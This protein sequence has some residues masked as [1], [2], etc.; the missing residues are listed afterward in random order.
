MR[1]LIQLQDKEIINELE[2]TLLKLKTKTNPLIKRSLKIAIP[3]KIAEQFILI[4]QIILFPYILFHLET[5]IFS[6]LIVLLIFCKEALLFFLKQ[7]KLKNHGNDHMTILTFFPGIYLFFL[8]LVLETD[9]SE[10]SLFLIIRGIYILIILSNVTSYMLELK[11]STIVLNCLALA[12]VISMINYFKFEDKVLS[13]EQ[14]INIAM[15]GT[16][17]FYVKLTLSNKYSIVQNFKITNEGQL[18]IDANQAKCKERELHNFLFSILDRITNLYI[19]MLR[20]SQC[21]YANS[22]FKFLCGNGNFETYLENF[23][24]IRTSID[25][26]YEDG[27]DQTDKVAKVLRCFYNYVS[28]TNLLEDLKKLYKDKRKDSNHERNFLLGIYEYNKR[29]FEIYFRFSCLPTG[30]ENLDLL[31][32]LAYELQEKNFESCI[33]QA[34]VVNSMMLNNK[35]GSSL[36]IPYHN[37]PTKRTLSLESIVIE[38]FSL[39]VNHNISKTMTY[40]LNLNN[41]SKDSFYNNDFSINLVNCH[42]KS[43]LSELNRSMKRRK[44]ANIKKNFSI[45]TKKVS[46]DGYS[47]SKSLKH[48]ALVKSNSDGFGLNVVNNSSMNPS[49]A[50]HELKT[51]LISIVSLCS[52]IKENCAD[53]HTLDHLEKISSIAQYSTILVIDFIDILQNKE[54]NIAIQTTPIKPILMFC[55]NILKSLALINSRNVECRFICFEDFENI[56]IDTDE[57]RLKQ[58]FLNFL[59]NSVKFTKSGSISIE[60]KI[61]LSHELVILIKDTGAGLNKT[62]LEKIKEQKFNS[63]H[64]DRKVNETGSGLGLNICFT[65]SKLLNYDISFDSELG[66][67]TEIQ[68]NLK[69]QYQWKRNSMS[70]IAEYQPSQLSLNSP[71]QESKQE[72]D[73]ND[74]FDFRM[75]S[76]MSFQ[77]TRRQSKSSDSPAICISRVKSIVSNRNLQVGSSPTGCGKTFVADEKPDVILVVDDN[78]LLRK[79]VKR[80]IDEIV[81]SN[82]LDYVVME[83]VDG[84]DIVKHVI[85]DQTKG[86]KIKFVFTDENMEYYNG[87]IASKMLKDLVSQSKIKFRPVMICVTSFMDESSKKEFVKNGFFDYVI[88]KNPGKEE[89]KRIIE[90]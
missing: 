64:I 27:L 34:S 84:I 26:Y 62:Q 11:A 57:L 51:P 22:N 77:Q 28:K 56:F 90:I 85:D 25:S 2:N 67:G 24:N 38:R 10:K 44:S 79:A 20:D 42:S 45:N 4:F 36:N 18:T 7:F 69:N 16:S 54:L 15:S 14:F 87:L 61:N 66:K 32:I 39:N 41:I 89:I 21:I 55:F 17:F 68:I 49:K 1:E 37:I 33:S 47:R 43:C 58:I 9:Y 83:G 6:G 40:N 75:A 3:M 5:R 70:D 35:Q 19:F 63:L 73:R 65:I 52:I 12:F 60:A 50:I 8:A 74:H 31:E 80:L 86:N 81:I 53:K 82:G 72:T 78:N 13:V 59:S 30:D 23:S 48:N 76:L 71:L 46:Q 88:D 29:Q